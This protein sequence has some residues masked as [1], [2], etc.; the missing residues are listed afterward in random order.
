MD[1]PVYDA[2][3]ICVTFTGVSLKPQGN[4]P[5]ID[6]VFPAPVQLDLLSLNADN[7]E[8]LLAAHPRSG[9]PLQLA[10]PA[11]ERGARRHDGL[12]CRAAKRRLRRDRGR[13]S[14]RQR[15][16]RQR[17]DDHGE[18]GDEL[19]DRLESAQGAQ[20][21]CRS[22]GALPAARSAHHRH[23]AVRHVDGYRRDAARHRGGLRQRSQPRHRQLRLYLRG[24]PA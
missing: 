14:E 24:L 3:Q 17:L 4:G 8:T 7:A 10:R 22:T 20:R 16:A 18:S 5:A 23:D 12:L 19:P 15:P 6:I 1:A 2:T 11:C 9:G 13:G 21:S